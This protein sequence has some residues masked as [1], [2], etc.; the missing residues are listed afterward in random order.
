[1][2]KKSLRL[3][4]AGLH[5]S[6]AELALKGIGQLVVHERDAYVDPAAAVAGLIEIHWNAILMVE[7]DPHV[8]VSVGEFPGVD[9]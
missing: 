7:P 2:P 5:L 1:L 3:A 8:L 6:R 4:E 9:V